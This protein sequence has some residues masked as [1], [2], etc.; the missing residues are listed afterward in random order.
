MKL[1]ALLLENDI[2]RM[3]FEAAEDYPDTASAW[4]TSATVI[5]VVI[6]GLIFAFKAVRK[7]MAD[8]VHRKIWTRRQTWL[9]IFMGLFPIFFLLCLVRWLDL[10]FA[11]FINLG[12]LFKGTLFAWLIYVSIMFAGHLVSPWRREII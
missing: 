9:T 8:V 5:A 4:M 10:D 12:D 1:I 3:L 7:S 11:A 2:L 6:A